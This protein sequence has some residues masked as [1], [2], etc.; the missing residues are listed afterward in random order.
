MY[1][2]GQKPTDGNI[3]VLLFCLQYLAEAQV[4]HLL[5]SGKIKNP[6]TIFS[7]LVFLVYGAFFYS[8]ERVNNRFPQRNFFFYSQKKL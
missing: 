7:L 4:N 2:K 5:T 8:F 6:E 1:K 3:Q